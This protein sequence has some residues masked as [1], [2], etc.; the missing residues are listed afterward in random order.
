MATVGKSG[1]MYI[2]GTGGGCGDSRWS[3][4]ACQSTV[5]YPLDI[6][7][8]NI[9]L[10]VYESTHT[11]TETHTHFRMESLSHTLYICPA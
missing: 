1:R 5:S 3:D 2:P 4:P 9:C 7:L 6:P 11:H 10:Y 8:I